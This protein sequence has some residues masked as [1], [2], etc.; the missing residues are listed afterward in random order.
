MV[1]PSSTFVNV[2]I[3]ESEN[4]KNEAPKGSNVEVNGE[5]CGRVP[6]K[7]HL[8]LLFPCFKFVSH[9]Q[10]SSVTLLVALVTI[11][12]LNLVKVME[13]VQTNSA[14]KCCDSKC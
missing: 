5:N 1:Q 8:P 12:S 13:R 10:I 9:V 7:Y 6:L 3:E 11:R 14:W 4:R 2:D